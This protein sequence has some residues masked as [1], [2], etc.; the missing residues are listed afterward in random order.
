MNKDAAYE[1]MIR[2]VGET[3]MQLCES[4]YV[5]YKPI[6]HDL[7]SRMTSE[8]EVEHTLDWML[9]F[10]GYEKVLDL[11]K[12]ICRKYIY[13]YPQMI[14]SEIQGYREMYDSDENSEETGEENWR[15]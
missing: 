7:C 9:D 11:F 4:A 15:R 3:Y 5:Q 6:T 2:S 1:E 14:S 10:C 13:I 8:D 12:M